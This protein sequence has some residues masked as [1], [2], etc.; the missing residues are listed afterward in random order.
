MRRARKMTAMS[1]T[2]RMT[3]PGRPISSKK[4]VR[5]IV[6]VARRVAWAIPVDVNWTARFVCM[7]ARVPGVLVLVL[8]AVLSTM[9]GVELLSGTRGKVAVCVTGCAV[10]VHRA[11]SAVLVI[12]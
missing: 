8:V 1:A 6:W 5:G 4:P 10:G 11:A 12:C 2:A 9:T 3:R 7:A